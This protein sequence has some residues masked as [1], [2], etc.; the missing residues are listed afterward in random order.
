MVLC[1]VGSWRVYDYYTL[2][3]NPTQLADSEMRMWKDYYSGNRMALGLE[4]VR[5]LR[6]QFKVPQNDA[7][8]IARDFAG[9]A[10]AFQGASGNYES[11]GLTPL[12]A[13]YARIRKVVG[14]DWSPE[15]A[16]RAELDWWV[17]RRTPGHDSSEEVGRGIAALYAIL[18]GRT[19]ARIERAG[20]LR[21]EAAR[22]RDQSSDWPQVQ[23]LLRESYSELAHGVR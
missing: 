11:V 18:Y 13:G 16:A 23:K 8:D 3:F 20:Y 15:K 7:Y 22:V 19:N 17:K 21:A 12:T 14:G 6:E 5:A 10:A 4:L 9:A 2:P 1:A